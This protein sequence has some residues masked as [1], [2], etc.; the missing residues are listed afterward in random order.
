[1]LWIWPMTWIVLPGES[2]F[3]SSVDDLVDVSRRRCRDRGLGCWRRPRRPAGCWPGWRWS[4]PQSRVKVATLLSMPGTGS[5]LRRQRRATGVLPRS[6]SELTWY[7]RRLHREVI[8]NAV[9]RIGPEIG[10]D[11]L[12]GAQA[13]IDVV[14]DL[15]GVEAELLRPAR[16]RSG[17]RSR[18]HRPPAADGR[19]RRPEWQRCGGAALRRCGGF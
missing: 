11:L 18:A 4:A 9:G 6:F 7:L 12:G 3:C 16:D 5:P 13:D 14:G 1:M 15:A 17:R 10:R 8:G 2:C 19:R